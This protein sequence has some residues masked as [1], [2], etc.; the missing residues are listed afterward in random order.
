MGSADLHIQMRIAYRVAH[1]LIRAA[2]SEHRK[3]AAERNP[4][5]RSDSG[6]DAYHIGLCDTAVKE[7]IRE[8]L[9]KYAGL[10]SSRQVSVQYDDVGVLR[11]QLLQSI[12]IAFSCCNLL[13]F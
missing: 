1:L 9:L 7:A 13:Y 4:S 6:R 11:S 2:C 3:G 10:G 12:A 5:C 8:R